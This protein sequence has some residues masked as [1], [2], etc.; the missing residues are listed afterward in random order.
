M[1]QLN[2]VPVFGA[3]KNTSTIG[4]KI[5]TEISVQIYGKRSRTVGRCKATEGTINQVIVVTTSGYSFKKRFFTLVS[6]KF[7]AFSV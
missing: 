1:L 2:P 7:T 4:R 3:K 6:F 5:F